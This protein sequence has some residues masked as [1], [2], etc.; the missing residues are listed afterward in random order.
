MFNKKQKIKKM[1]LLQAKLEEYKQKNEK[2]NEYLQ[3]YRKTADEKY[4]RAYAGASFGTLPIKWE[5]NSKFKLTDSEIRDL[6]GYW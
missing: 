5:L 4:Y 3:L 6:T 2:A 1:L